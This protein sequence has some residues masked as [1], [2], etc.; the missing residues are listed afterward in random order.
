MKDEQY[1]YSWSGSRDVWL[2]LVCAQQGVC[3][4]TH[5][6][7]PSPTAATVW[8]FSPE[9]SFASGSEGVKMAQHSTGKTCGVPTKRV[10]SVKKICGISC[11]VHCKYQLVIE[12]FHYVSVTQ[13]RFLSTA[14]CDC[15]I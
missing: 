3:Y 14:E 11:V 5:S 1:L 13:N 6:T 12:H 8:R 2:G 15:N 9:L 7:V 4:R 10:R